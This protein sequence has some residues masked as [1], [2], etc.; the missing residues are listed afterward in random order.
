MK[1]RRE[2]GELE[3]K[4]SE[5]SFESEELLKMRQKVLFLESELTKMQAENDNLHL[6]LESRPTQKQLKS[7]EKELHSLLQAQSSPNIPYFLSY[8]S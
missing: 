5:R 6:E 3:R 1:L 8:N 2:K 4:S 7:K